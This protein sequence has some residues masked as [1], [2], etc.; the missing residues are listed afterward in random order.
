MPVL[1]F[2]FLISHTGSV[3]KGYCGVCNHVFVACR[4]LKDPDLSQ[5]ELTVIYRLLTL[6]VEGYAKTVS[7]QLKSGLYR[8][9]QKCLQTAA[10][11]GKYQ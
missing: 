9:S 2:F 3:L 8:H 1:F 4:D 7:N 6:F 10:S 5:T 11:G